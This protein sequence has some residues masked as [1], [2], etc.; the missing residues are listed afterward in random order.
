MKAVFRLTAATV[1]SFVKVQ[2]AAKTIARGLH[3]LV[4]AGTVATAAPVSSVDT[5]LRDSQKFVL[6]V[7]GK[8]FVLASVQARMDKLRYW[9]DWDAAAREAIVKRAADD[10]FNTLGIP[11]HWYE[12]EP[13]K[14]NWSWA[15]LDEYLGVAHKYGLKV[16]LL[17]FGHNSGGQVQWLGDPAKNPVHLRTPDYVFYSPAPNSKETTSDFTIN[18]ARATY[19]LDLTDTRLRARETEVVGKMM[20]HIAEW[21]TAHGSPHTVIGVQI[22]NEVFGGSAGVATSYLSDVASAVKKSPYVVWTRVNTVRAATVSRIEENEKLRQTEGTNVD[23]TGADLYR[24]DA[25]FIRTH[26]PYRGLNFRMIMESSAVVPTPAQFQLAALSGNTAWSYYDLCGPDKYGLYDREGAS[27]FRPNSS[28]IE[29]VRVLNRLLTSD[30]VDLA[31]NAH[32]YGLFVHNWEGKSAA[33]TV[34]VD[35]IVFTPVDPLSQAISIRRSNTELVLMN[36][37]GGKFTFP[38]ALGVSAAAKGHFDRDNRWVEEGKV[39][40]AKTEITP[41][42]G[43]TIRLLRANSREPATIRRQAEFAEVGGGAVVDA[44]AD[45]LGFAGNGYVKFPLADGYL[46][47]T[48]V[49]GL[50]GGE[51]TVRFRYANGDAQGHKARVFINGEERSVSFGPTGSWENY[52]YI[53]FT[54]SLRPGRANKIRVETNGGGAGNIDELQTF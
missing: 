14:N 20:A 21:D 22:G 42:P 37:Q 51:R 48:E 50:A 24:V 17:W 6:R 26:V 5:D 27:G 38:E 1:T 18:R 52:E 47:W 30:P 4:A 49:D 9:W 13:T 43:V 15:I 23:F 31:L 32:G 40:F 45:S 8:P 39:P 29:E 54:T 10:G 12:I 41:E 7:D 3:L 19:Q 2:L 34:G 53:A 44:A 36:T 25:A 35:G 33:P 16:E 28:H 11:I 46:T